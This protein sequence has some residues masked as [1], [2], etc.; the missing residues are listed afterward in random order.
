MSATIHIR[1]HHKALDENYVL[2]LTSNKVER[3]AVNKVLQNVCDADIA[4]NTR[5]CNIG[6]LG[7]RLA[8]HVTGDSGI[9]K[10]LSVGRIATSLL[11]DP[12]FP[13]PILVLLVGFCWGNPAFA[14]VGS[15]VV[16]THVSSLN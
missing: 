5:G 3:A 6:Q 10:E 16:S 7:R 11:S 2:L 8:L 12:Q 13:K 14:N 1:N 4:R 15:V 9:S